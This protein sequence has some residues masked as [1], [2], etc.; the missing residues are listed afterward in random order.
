MLVMVDGILTLVKLVQPKNVEFLIVV[1]ELGIVTDVRLVQPEK[2][3][4]FML[5]TELGMLYELFSNAGGYNNN[6][7]FA[8]LNNTPFSVKNLVLLLSITMLDKLFVKR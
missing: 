2:A 7:V 6:V 3:E 4:E 1:T 5:V 8:L